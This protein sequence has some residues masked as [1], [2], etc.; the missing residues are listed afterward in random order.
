MAMTFE[1]KGNKLCIEI[2]LEKPTRPASGKTLFAAS[3]QDGILGVA[4]SLRVYGKP[5][6]WQALR[7]LPL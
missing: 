1:I 2:D 5:S 3:T 4:T 6:Q 7:E